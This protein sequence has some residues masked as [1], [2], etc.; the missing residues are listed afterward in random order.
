MIL[1]IIFRKLNFWQFI[2]KQTSVYSILTKAY[3]LSREKISRS[4]PF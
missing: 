1:K 4:A 2:S 3:P